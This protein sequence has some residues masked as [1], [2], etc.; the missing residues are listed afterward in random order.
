MNKE[1]PVVYYIGVAKVWY[2][3]DD[4]TKPV[5]SLPLVLDHP[6]LGNCY[7]VRTSVIVQQY[8]DGTIETRNT[9]YKPI[10][11]EGMGS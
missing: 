5:A 3:N 7:N 10:A 9:I 1:K 6:Q 2:W 8:F 11:T 4:I